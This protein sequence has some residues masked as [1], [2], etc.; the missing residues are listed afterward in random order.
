METETTVVK[1]IPIPSIVVVAGLVATIGIGA[2]FFLN[3]KEESYRQ[4]QVYEVDG[5]ANVDR[6]SV[7]I[8]QA[9]AN[10]MLQSKDIVNVSDNSNMQVKLDEDK[11]ILLEPGTKIHL[12][13]T[14]T[15]VDSKTKIYLEQG[16]IVCNLENKL[17]ENSSY[18]VNTPN[19]TMAVR[20]TTFR[21]A[22]EYD[23]NNNSYTV[24]GVYDGIVESR[25]IYPDG[26][27]A[28]ECVSITY[29]TEV[30]I[31]GTDEDSMYL[32]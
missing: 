21:V 12:E 19:S 3:S 31:K 24:V 25:L 29:D 15:S 13:A 8:L 28:K 9:Y 30:H 27:I 4:I 11:Y 2:V 6:T 20:G 14:G 1:K 5:S 32:V 17:N 10:M 26:S 23:E 22:L 16:A 7:G 18:E